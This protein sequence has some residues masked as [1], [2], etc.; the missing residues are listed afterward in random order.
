[1]YPLT[2]TSSWVYASAIAVTYSLKYHTRNSSSSISSFERSFSPL[3]LVPFSL[4]A[5]ALRVVTMAS[6]SLGSSG[7]QG[8]THQGSVLPSPTDDFERSLVLPG[9]KAPTALKMVREYCSKSATNSSVLRSPPYLWSSASG[10]SQWNNV[11]IGSIPFASNSSTRS[12]GIT[13]D[14]EMLN[15]VASHVSIFIAGDLAWNMAEGI[16]DTVCSAVFMGSPFDLHK[17]GVTS[18]KDA[19]EILTRLQTRSQISKGTNRSSFDTA[20]VQPRCEGGK[21]SAV[22]PQFL[23][24]NVHN[25]VCAAAD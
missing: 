7:S 14:H 21:S 10:R 15:R 18:V 5:H 22:G 25:I 6:I 23:T 13:R 2:S 17:R 9:A 11:T 12:I 24:P 8:S 20:L 3:R 19:A 16:P 4:F 1:M